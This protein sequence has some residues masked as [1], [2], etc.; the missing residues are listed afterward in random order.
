MGAIGLVVDSPFVYSRILSMGGHYNEFV[1]GLPVMLLM[2]VNDI[3]L[4]PA[5]SMPGF[6]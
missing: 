4:P 6:C 5:G 3:N 1:T 2:C